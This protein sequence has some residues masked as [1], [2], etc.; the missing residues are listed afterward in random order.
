MVA[1]IGG[2]EAQE[3]FYNKGCAGCHQCALT[4]YRRRMTHAEEY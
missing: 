4:H 2:G 1:R 3:Q